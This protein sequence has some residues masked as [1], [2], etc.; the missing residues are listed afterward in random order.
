MIDFGYV[1]F[2]DEFLEIEKED[3]EKKFKKAYNALNKFLQK[4]LNFLADNFGNKIEF[5]NELIADYLLKTNF[6]NFSNAIIKINYI[7]PENLIK[8]TQNKST[9][10]RLKDKFIDDNNKILTP[11][12]VVKFLQE[13]LNKEVLNC[14]ATIRK[15]VM[16]V[17]IYGFR[18]YILVDFNIEDSFVLFNRRHNI[19]QLKIKQNLLN[20]DKNTNGNFGK[21]LR[22]VKNI[23]IELAMKNALSGVLINKIYL[24]EN[25]L[26]NVPDKLFCEEFTYINF[27]N[28]ITYLTN[29]NPE[30]FITLDEQKLLSCISLKDYNN[31]ITNNNIFLENVKYFFEN[32]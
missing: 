16:L 6:K 22:F 32:E 25:I 13:E 15:N 7:A 21:V 10:R 23:E 11:N 14:K 26:F 31:F 12:E 2:F 4:S 28:A 1:K 8:N 3:Y 29:S 24:Y 30:N 20:K 18:F 9:Y 5:K 27:L 19:N 17:K